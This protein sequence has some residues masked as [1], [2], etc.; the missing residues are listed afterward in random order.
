MNM[1]IND[2]FNYHAALLPGG[3]SF[4]MRA[5]D[6]AYIPL[7]LENMDYQEFLLWMS[8]GNPAPEG[9][10]GPTNQSG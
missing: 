10:T 5:S 7:N 4:V 2:S 3:Q 6:G 1:A 8:E 9:W